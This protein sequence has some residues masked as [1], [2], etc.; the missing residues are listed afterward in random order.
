[1][2]HDDDHAS[3]EQDVSLARDA[4][5]KGDLGHALHHIGCA[6][7]SNPMQQ[8]WMG[9]LNQVVGQI[10][11][12]PDPLS[13]VTIEGDTS[14]ID[15]ANRAFVLAWLRKWEEALDLITDVAEVRPDVPYLLWAEWWL[16]QPGAI[17]SMTWDQFAGG[18]LV[19]LM[20]IAASCPPKMDKDDPRYVNVQAAARI[21]GLIRNVHGNRSFVWIVASV[22]G[23]RLGANDDVLAMAQHAYKL[24]AAWNSATTVANVLRDLGRLDEARQWFHRAMD[25]DQDAVGAWLDC[26]DM[27]LDADRLDDAI[28]EYQRVLKKEPDH[29]WAVPSLRYA[30]YKKLGDPNRKLALLRMTEQG[31]GNERAQE[32]AHRLDPPRP[33]VT[34]LPRPA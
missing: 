21:I 16:T 23:R 1:M 10:A 4:L 25:H 12:Q 6:L 31:D 24:E 32:L 18:I 15:G 2:A 17:E 33:F 19:D 8:E 26:G 9:V 30:E 13:L 7:A 20:K 5:A 29:P 27:M 28:A 14:F 22:I 11:Q 34:F 3:P